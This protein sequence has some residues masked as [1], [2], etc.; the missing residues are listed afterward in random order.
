MKVY[1]ALVVFAK[2]ITDCVVLTDLQSNPPSW[3][4]D[5]T[6]VDS[7]IVAKEGFSDI[8]GIST[9]WEILLQQA[10][11]FEVFE[12]DFSE[13]LIII[14]YTTYLPAEQTLSRSDHKWTKISD[15][16]IKSNLGLIIRYFATQR[17]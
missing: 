10:G 7:A 4:I 1:S 15:I 14:V 12:N 16:D 13:K 6:T 2:N 3:I 9:S 8:T 11:T 5:D 17:N